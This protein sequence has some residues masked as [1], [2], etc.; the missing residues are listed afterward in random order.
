MP[1]LAIIIPV[2]N[3]SGLIPE[4]LQRLQ[5]LRLRGAAVI[6][7]DGGS[8]DGT[9]E[10]AAPLADRVISASRGRGRQMNA[11][12]AAAEA[13]VLLF[14]HADT[15]LPPDADLL[16]HRALAG[17]KAWGRFDVQIDSTRASLRLVSA[18]MNWRSRWSG[19]ATGDQGM[20]VRRETFDALGGFRN[21][22]LMEDIDMSSRLRRIGPPACVPQRVV[23]S[24][25]RWHQHGVLRTVL[26]MWK[27]RAA[28][29]FG[30]H[31][32]KLAVQYG[33]KPHEP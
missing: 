3:E 20:F 11:G 13:G 18:M 30:A 24:A 1:E 25:R 31:P 19:I 15:A 16:I 10:R 23:T 32:D 5:L 28:F 29:F 7:V 9:P 4:T 8:E 2:V 22:A 27:L 33:Y 14:L 17:G 6:V 26:F 21:V 12:A